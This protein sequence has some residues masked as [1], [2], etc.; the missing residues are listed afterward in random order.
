MVSRIGLDSMRVLSCPASMDA[1]ELARFRRRITTAVCD[2]QIRIFNGVTVQIA[3]I[4]R[5]TCFCHLFELC[6]RAPCLGHS[7][8]GP[9]RVFSVCL[10]LGLGSGLQLY[11]ECFYHRDLT[12]N[13][14]NSPCSIKASRRC[15]QLLSWCCEN[16][17]RSHWDVRG[18]RAVITLLENLFFEQFIARN[19]S[20]VQL[21]LRV[22]GMLSAALPPPHG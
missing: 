18:W 22:V 5:D 2:H 10:G 17:D 11:L 21:Y 6:Q 12:T 8:A 14:V 7:V 15:Q 13:R 20:L 9:T 4:L 19:A 1:V 3:H 16:E